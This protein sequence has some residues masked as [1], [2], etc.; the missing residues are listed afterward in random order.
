MICR[1]A[2]PLMSAI[3]SN[4]ALFGALVDGVVYVEEGRLLRAAVQAEHLHQGAAAS[5][6]GAPGEVVVELAG[7]EN[8]LGGVFHLGAELG[9]A[10]VRG[11]F[12]AGFGVAD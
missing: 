1:P 3:G 5:V 4:V 10:V 11:E 9:R 7:D 2:E 8:P 12:L 6:D